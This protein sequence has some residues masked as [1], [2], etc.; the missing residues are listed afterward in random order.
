MADIAMRDLVRA[1]PKFILLKREHVLTAYESSD[2]GL[3]L[4]AQKMCSK[5]S[6]LTIAY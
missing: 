3:V 5:W 4:T 6:L 2:L 1:M